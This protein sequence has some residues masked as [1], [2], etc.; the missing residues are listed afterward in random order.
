MVRDIVGSYVKF[1]VLQ[2][3]QCEQFCSKQILA[4]FVLTFSQHQQ[5]TPINNKHLYFYHDECRPNLPSNHPHGHS[6]LCYLQWSSTQAK[7]EY[8]GPPTQVCQFGE[9]FP[10]HE[11]Y[12]S[13][14]IL[15]SLSVYF[16]FTTP[17]KTFS[18]ILARI[19]SLSSWVPLLPS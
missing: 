13:H 17:R 8:P 14:S 11:P 7:G 5:L 6:P 2:R 19:R 3:C 10:F 16:S 18:R 9:S 15:F 1:L 4:P 12:L